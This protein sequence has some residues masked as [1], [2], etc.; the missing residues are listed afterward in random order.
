MNPGQSSDPAN[1]REYHRL[2]FRATIG[3]EPLQQDLKTQPAAL[4]ARLRTALREL[5]WLQLE[6]Q[7]TLIR[8]SLLRAMPNLVPAMR[9]IDAK[10]NFLAAELFSTESLHAGNDTV[11]MSATGIDF[12]WPEHLAT[13]SLWLLEIAPAG[14]GPTLHLPAVIVRADGTDSGYHIAAEFFGLTA[15]EIDT[16]ASW[17]VSREAKALIEENRAQHPSGED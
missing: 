17:V 5:H 4:R 8:E 12:P 13:G 16:L 9:V 14:D 10:L 7:Q 11:R 15:D 3:V 6:N 2:E 1:R